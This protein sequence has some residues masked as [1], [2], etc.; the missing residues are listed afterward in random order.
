MDTQPQTTDSMEK[1]AELINEIKFAMLT[2]QEHDG[3]LHSRP[4]TTLQVD[5]DGCLWFFTGL[6]SYKVDDLHEHT[7]VN[8]AY[9]RTDKQD[10]LSVTGT[11]EVVRDRKKMEQ[12]WTPWLKPWFHGGLDDPEL[13]LLKVRIEEANYW[14][15]PGSMVKRLYGL[16]KGVLT[17]NTDALGGQGRVVNPH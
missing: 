13:V 6:H 5:S 7:K 11:A 9:A 10:Y 16:A 3:N 1:V 8:V 2:T 4:M 17:G 14:D 12:L 15:A